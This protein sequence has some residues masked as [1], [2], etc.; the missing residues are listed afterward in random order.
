MC[1][2]QVNYV[3]RTDFEESVVVVVAAM[4]MMTGMMTVRHCLLEKLTA[5]SLLNKFTAFCGT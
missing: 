4:M 1:S 5:I 2:T 3:E